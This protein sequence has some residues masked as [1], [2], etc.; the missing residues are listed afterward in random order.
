MYQ[1]LLRMHAGSIKMC[2]GTSAGLHLQVEYFFRCKVGVSSNKHTQDHSKQDE[3]MVMI[4]TAFPP[5]ASGIAQHMLA[6][7]CAQRCNTT[8]HVHSHKWFIISNE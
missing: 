3:H 2:F 6:Q 1:L 7:G 4:S 8:Q 5:N